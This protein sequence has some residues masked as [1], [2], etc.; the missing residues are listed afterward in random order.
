MTAETMS[1]GDGYSRELWLNAVAAALGLTYSAYRQLRA[2]RTLP[3]GPWGVPFLGYAP[4]LSNHCTYLKYNELARRYGSICSFTQ[5]GNTV[6]LLSDHKLIKT[7]F[8]MK[9]IT[10]R[11]N[12]GY[13]DIIGGYG[14]VN[15]TGKLWESQRKFLHLVLR[16]MGMTFTGHNRLNMENRIMIEVSTLTETFHKTCGK[17]IDLNAGSLCLAITNVISSLTMSVRFEPN[18]PRFERYM[19]MVDE[20]F[21]LFGMLRPV[22]LF[23][24]RRHITDERN[25]QEKIKNNHQEI[26]KYFQSIIEE[27]RS[28]FDPNSIRD[29]VDAYLLEIK[30][31]QEAGTMDQLFQGLDP[32]RQVQQILGDLFSAGMETIKNTILWAMV[33]MLHYPDVMTKVQD[34]IDS[35]VGQY[36][37]P[38]LDDYPNLPYTQATLYEVLRKSSITPLGT[39]HATTSDV[40]LNGYH[41]P[42]GAQII[43]LQHFVHNDP[44]LWDEP[45]AFK[46]ERFI[47]AEGKV[48]KPDCFLPF[49]VGRRKCL[50]ETLA[51]ME[52][53]L[54][55]ST[56]LHEFDVCLPDGDELP[57]MDGQ[58]GITLTPQSF[59]VVMRARNK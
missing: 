34:E 30:R 56:L 9:Q 50:G 29:L 47:N 1:D 4:F 33:Y 42:T 32:N 53:Y 54:F 25:I 59:K 37:S 17:P 28:T 12:D 31:S 19:H 23:L 49:G 27:H 46:P 15:S 21:K 43:P 57:S 44:N 3:P 58:V 2:A 51:Q 20:G 7:A 8:D 14:A 36:K 13:M 38:V 10:G 39:T 18:D 16:H 45:E 24:P 22:S 41:I 26:A 35:V 52:L 6:I 55:F 5:R 40:T 11:P 48:K